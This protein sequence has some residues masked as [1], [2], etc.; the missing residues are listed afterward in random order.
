MLFVMKMMRYPFHSICRYVT[1]IH[2]IPLR[3][4]L[5]PTGYFGVA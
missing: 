1:Y 2:K 3:M 5:K 4:A